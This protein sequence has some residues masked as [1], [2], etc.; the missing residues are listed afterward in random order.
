[1]TKKWLFGVPLSVLLFGTLLAWFVHQDFRLERQHQ[2]QLEIS[3]FA[4]LFRNDLETAFKE[5][6]SQVLALKA[7]YESSR[8]VDPDE[9]AVFAA[10]LLG[11]T[12]G[13]A[14]L[15]WVP[16]LNNQTL[17]R[18]QQKLAKEGFT[19]LKLESESVDNEGNP[20]WPIA[21]AY[22]LDSSKD[23]GKNLGREPQQLRQLTES[24]DKG[25]LSVLGSLNKNTLETVRVIAPV[26]R[27][28]SEID[29]RRK[30]MGFVAGRI[31]VSL[32]VEQVRQSYIRRYPSF[33]GTLITSES[34]NEITGVF[35]PDIESKTVSNVVESVSLANATLNLHF[36]ADRQAWF[37]RHPAKFG[38]SAFI[39]CFSMLFAL[40]IYLYLLT[41][42]R[43]EHIRRVNL[44]LSHFNESLEKEVGLRTKDLERS[45]QELEQFAYAASHDLQEPLR[46]IISISDILAEELSSDLSGENLKYFNHLMN[47]AQR[48]RDL[49]QDLLQFSRA[50]VKE[51]HP[52]EV[53]FQK[54]IQES[55]EVQRD[56][57][58]E[59]GAEI[60]IGKM[61]TVICMESLLRQVFINLIS[62]SL[63][64]HKPGHQP[65]IE[66]KAKAKDDLWVFS[67]SDNGIGID[68]EYHQ[69]IFEIFQRLHRSQV[70]PGTGIGLALCKR[71][72]NRH[73]GELWLKSHPNKGTTFYFS[74]PKV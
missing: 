48:M 60:K 20:F 56:K 67:V 10:H 35:A 7:Y 12:Q 47:S 16:E 29:T 72:I 39:I 4:T 65:L 15:E 61:P 42:I 50:G 32:L 52:K 41:R 31:Q 58:E 68:P 40:T 34:S 54:I 18:L 51:L 27:H 62:N 9:F 38:M 11:G 3:H 2:L 49:I 37:K 22:P 19:T 59:T 73:G 14:T 46:K 1:M 30:F 24:R 74:L 36:K 45:N 57:V 6:T 44:K 63:K 23:L 64:F 53:N 69:K 43:A 25:S 8:F 28:G 66:I 21:Y 5:R 33:T 71:V 55:I 70:Y 13:I 17:K 26:Y